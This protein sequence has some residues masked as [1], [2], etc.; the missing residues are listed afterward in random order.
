MFVRSKTFQ[1]NICIACRDKIS[2]QNKSHT[3]P[4]PPSKLIQPRRS[5][6][7]QL[8]CLLGQGQASAA[9]GSAGVPATGT[10]SPPL[11]PRGGRWLIKREITSA[12]EN[13]PQPVR[14]RMVK[15]RHQYRRHF[16]PCL[17][18]AKTRISVSCI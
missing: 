1:S 15:A 4:P 14:R 7:Q 12:T 5:R 8:C 18:Q 9:L 13:H 6:A 16:K 11:S 17:P 10:E 2:S 3:P